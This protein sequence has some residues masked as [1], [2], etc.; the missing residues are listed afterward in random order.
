MAW[1]ESN[2]D[3]FSMFQNWFVKNPVTNMEQDYV[4]CPLRATLLCLELHPDM[5][6][7]IAGLLYNVFIEPS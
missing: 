4:N 3:L 2:V 5:A 1:Y 7:E 6:S